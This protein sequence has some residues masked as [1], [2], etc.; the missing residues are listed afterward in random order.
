MTAAAASRVAAFLG[1]GVGKTL[2]KLRA[3]LLARLPLRRETG[4]VTSRYGVRMRANWQDR[5][6]RYCYYATY[7]RA[8]SDYLAA[9]DRAFVFVD[10]GANQGLFSLLAAQNPQCAAAIAFEPVAATFALLRDNIA[11]NGLEAAVRPVHAAVSLQS[12]NARIATDRAHSG[13]A[14]L[15]GAAPADGEDIRILGISGVDTLIDG[16]GPLIVKIDVEGH[17]EAVIEALMASAHLG[18]I[19]AIFYE[20]DERWTDAAAIARRLDSAGFDRLTRFGIGRHYD[21]L[22]ER[23]DWGPARE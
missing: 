11:L 16:K 9:Q 14:S 4:A 19:A 23:G 10:I 17:E 7:G 6:F 15:R 1:Y 3:N 20:V 2:A 21:V 13:T 5:T 12:G 18:R 8:L 22:A